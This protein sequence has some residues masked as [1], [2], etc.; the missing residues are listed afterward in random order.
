MITLKIKGSKMG[1]CF[2]NYIQRLIIHNTLKKNMK[3][4]LY[5]VIITF[6]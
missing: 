2:K 5:L 3:S 4:N 1:V 6:K